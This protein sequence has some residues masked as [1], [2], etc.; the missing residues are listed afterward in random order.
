MSY[1]SQLNL[2]FT[3]DP[4]FSYSITESKDS[5]KINNVRVGVRLLLEKKEVGQVYIN[6]DDLIEDQTKYAL[7]NEQGNKAYTIALYEKM[8]SD[9][10][11]NLDKLKK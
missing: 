11:Q 1:S 3:T 5:I 6:L 10:Q 2:N 9:L 4:D 8:I 7:K